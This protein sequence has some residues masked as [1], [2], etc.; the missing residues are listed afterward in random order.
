MAGVMNM[1]RSEL[2]AK[3]IELLDELKK[4]DH[5]AFLNFEAYYECGGHDSASLI[6]GIFDMESILKG[7]M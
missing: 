6:E 4:K 2:Q 7:Q 5:E 1:T 3:Y